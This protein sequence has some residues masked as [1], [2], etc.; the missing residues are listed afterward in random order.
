MNETALL[1]NYLTL[2]AILFGLGLIGFT[3]R[4]NIIVMFLCAELML[5]GV[6][7]N[8]V[9]WGRHHN[10]WG[11]Q[12]LVVFIITI[13]ACEAGIALVLILMLAKQAGNL[14]ITSWQSVREDGTEAFVDREIPEDIDEEKV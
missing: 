5:Q 9:A 1:H 13:A 12:A 4:R 11:G 14:D 6:S 2:G 8:L 7:L 3:V 10:D